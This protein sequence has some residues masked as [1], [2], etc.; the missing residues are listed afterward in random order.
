MEMTRQ[1]N[2]SNTIIHTCERSMIETHHT[3]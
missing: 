2:A 3:V 1:K